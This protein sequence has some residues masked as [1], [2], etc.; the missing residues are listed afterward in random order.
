MC[1][2]YKDKSNFKKERL[3]CS[4]D[5]WVA[6]MCEA[7]GTPGRSGVEE[8]LES[9]HH[10]PGVPCPLLLVRQCY[11]HCSHEYLTA[12][13]TYLS[14]AVQSHKAPAYIGHGTA[15]LPPLLTA[16]L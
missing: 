3:T 16:L 4:L 6:A 10:G 2:T 7:V 13:L 15:Q 5:T 8:P 11:Y 14:S 1:T 12:S 9:V